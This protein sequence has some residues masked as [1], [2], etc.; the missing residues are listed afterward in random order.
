V[1]GDV[2]EEGVVEEGVEAEAGEEAV[3][4]EA[5]GGPSTFRTTTKTRSILLL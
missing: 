2:V 5:D 1:E 4:A 3:V